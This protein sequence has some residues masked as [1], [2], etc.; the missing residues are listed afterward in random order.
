MMGR[1][2]P[3]QGIVGYGPDS[4]DWYLGPVPFVHASIAQNG[5]SLPE[6]NDNA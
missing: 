5:N 6:S 3:P 2:S 1:A 4:C